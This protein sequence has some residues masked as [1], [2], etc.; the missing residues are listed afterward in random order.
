[1]LICEKCGATFDE[2]KIIKELHPY[3]MGTAA[4]EWAVCPHCESTSIAEAQLCK[5]CDTYVVELLDGELCEC[6]CGDLYGE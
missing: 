4:E 2:P 1:M 3:G 5:R 6:C